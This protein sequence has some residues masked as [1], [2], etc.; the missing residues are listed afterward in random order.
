MVNIE[1]IKLIHKDISQTHQELIQTLDSVELEILP[2]LF[3]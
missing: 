1:K 3:T 2:V